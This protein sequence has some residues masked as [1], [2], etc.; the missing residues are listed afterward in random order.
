ML[1]LESTGQFQSIMLTESFFFLSLFVLRES[2]S[3]SMKG[4]GAEREGERIIA[5]SAW[6]PDAG[7]KPTN[8][9]I[10]TR[11][12]IK[13]QTFNGLSHP[14]APNRDFGNR[15]YVLSQR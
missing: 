7:L 8:P 5:G 9:E 2:E 13:S 15:N 11:A 12:Q 10:M 1:V 3:V 4:G 14:G 6:T